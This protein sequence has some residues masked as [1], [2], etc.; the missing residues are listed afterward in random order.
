V[1]AI[2][3]AL[4]PLPTAVFCPARLAKVGAR[5]GS[6]RHDV[7]GK[8]VCQSMFTRTPGSDADAEP[9]VIFQHFCLLFRFIDPILR[10]PVG[11]PVWS[12]T[13]YTHVD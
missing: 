13:C 10:Q 12:R 8:A 5:L 11:A 9:A 1:G 2:N 6:P 7:L 3:C 4:V